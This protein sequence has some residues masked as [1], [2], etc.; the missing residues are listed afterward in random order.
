MSNKNKEAW[1]TPLDSVIDASAAVVEV[2]T[3][4]Q[5]AGRKRI[6]ARELLQECADHLMVARANLRDSGVKDPCLIWKYDLKKCVVTDLETLIA[7]EIQRNKKLLVKIPPTNLLTPMDT[8]IMAVKQT[9]VVMQGTKVPGMDY[10]DA[11]E[12]LEFVAWQLEAARSRAWK[13]RD[14][15]SC[16]YDWNGF[17]TVI[18]ERD[19]KKVEEMEAKRAAAQQS[20]EEGEG[21]SNE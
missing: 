2:L 18:V 21:Q 11:R 6:D 14:G 10:I 3:G 15:D 17:M 7:K 4:E 9:G 12:F 8:A 5:L 19:M 1:F 13:T 16:L 20:I